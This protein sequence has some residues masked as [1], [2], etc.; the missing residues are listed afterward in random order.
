MYQNHEGNCERVSLIET[1]FFAFLKIKFKLDLLS[2]HI[3]Y[4]MEAQPSISMQ[5][6]ETL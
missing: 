5:L 6:L 2:K 4:I 1:F 3:T